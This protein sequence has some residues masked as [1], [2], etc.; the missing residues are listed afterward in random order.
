MTPDAQTNNISYANSMVFP[1]RSEHIP[2]TFV[3]ILYSC[4]E[5]LIRKEVQRAH[6]DHSGIVACLKA[7]NQQCV[8]ADSMGEL[9]THWVIHLYSLWSGGL[10]QF[11]HVTA[12]NF[13]RNII[14]M[15]QVTC[16]VAPNMCLLW[17]NYCRYK[18]YT[19]G[20][21]CQ[22]QWSPSWRTILNCKARASPIDR[23][24]LTV[25]WKWTPLQWSSVN[26]LLLLWF[27]PGAQYT[28]PL[29]TCR[30]TK[31]YHH[32]NMFDFT[33][34]RQIKCNSIH[35]AEINFTELRGKRFAYV[36][37]IGYLGQ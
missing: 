2:V 35:T 18:N 10:K 7:S 13:C 30:V 17:Q 9:H 36:Y 24:P 16:F 20:S 34:M 5:K 6:K 28:Q 23:H 21:S 29:K 15:Q 19:G 33:G 12:T 8:G 26:W 1:Y 31:Y 4:L 11:F 32:L 3:C 37:T 14:L 27:C 25:P 22:W